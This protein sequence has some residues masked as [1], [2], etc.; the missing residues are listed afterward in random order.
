M[1]VLHTDLDNTLIYR[2]VET[3]DVNRVCVEQYR[4]KPFSFMTAESVRLV[5]ELTDSN[6]VTIVPITTRNIEQYKR[7][8]LRN[9][10]IALVANGGVLL[11]NGEVDKSWYAE[12]IDYAQSC[13]Y[14]FRRVTKIIPNAVL[15]E[16]LY[17][18]AKV[19]D[20]E[21]V[22]GQLKKVL[23]LSKVSVYNLKSKIY[24]VP[25]QLEK[26]AAIER[27]K[28]RLSRTITLA[29]GD[30][31]IDESMFGAADISFTATPELEHYNTMLFE[32]KVFSDDMLS[33]IQLR[34]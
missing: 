18:F 15:V 22:V 31:I 8:E 17:L 9:M 6:L 34:I 20:S 30:C 11:Q 13:V 24:V 10:P 12:S 5:Q 3:S 16:N 32:N 19:I 26:G 21:S 23:D 28:A 29:A 25:K 33:Y 1:V 7:I 2:D 14:E 27:L 4:G